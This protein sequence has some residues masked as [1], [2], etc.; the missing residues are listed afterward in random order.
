MTDQTAILCLNH[1]LRAFDMHPFLLLAKARILAHEGAIA[2]PCRHHDRCCP[3]DDDYDCSGMTDG[4]TL[5]RRCQRPV[6]SHNVRRNQF[7][8][9]QNAQRHNDEIVHIAEHR[10][11]V[12]NEINRRERIA[13][14]AKSQRLGVPRHAGIA[15]RPIDRVHVSFG[16][17][18]PLS[19]SLDHRAGAFRAS[20]TSIRLK[21]SRGRCV[22]R[23]G[24]KHA[25]SCFP[26]G[27]AQVVRHHGERCV[28]SGPPLPE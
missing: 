26:D 17:T 12:G 16:K 13:G 27:R 24:R 7:E 21:M 9:D 18:R 4:P 25:P 11:E 6:F 1:D 15:R 10:H 5:R 8:H 28:V 14:D 3:D 23:D 20:S 19:C 2:E 22:T